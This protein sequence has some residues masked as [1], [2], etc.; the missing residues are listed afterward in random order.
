[1]PP[2]P[3]TLDEIISMFDQGREQ[4]MALA[5]RVVPVDDPLRPDPS[6]LALG[7]RQRH[8]EILMLERG[9]HAS[10]LWS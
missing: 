1:M 3:A 4:L 10:D 8:R 2:A 7:E 6:P 5:A 9:R